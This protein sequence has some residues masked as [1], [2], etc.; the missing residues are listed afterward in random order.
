MGNKKVY[1]RDKEKDLRVY[2]EAMEQ[3]E[4]SGGEIIN[5]EFV[6]RNPDVW[7]YFLHLKLR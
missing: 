7:Y 3:F 1:K 6:R 2:R 4:L 5:M